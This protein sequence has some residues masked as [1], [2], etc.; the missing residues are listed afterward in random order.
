[1]KLDPEIFV[2][3]GMIALIAGVVGARLSHVLENWSQFTN[4]DRG[5]FGNLWD[6][7]NIRT[8][9]LTFY[10]GFILA[11]PITIAYGIYR[12]VPIKRG[13]DIVAP[14]VMIGLGLGRVGC[15]L[16][17]CCYGAPTDASFIGAVQY[18][19]YSNAYQDQ[20]YKG[21][22]KVPEQLTA[23]S[24]GVLPRL[25][26]TT[27]VSARSQRR[28][29]RGDAILQSGS[30]RANLQHDHCPSDRGNLRGVFLDDAAAGAGNGVNADA[31]RNDAIH[32]GIAALRA[33]RGACHGIRLEFEHGDRR[34]ARDHRNHHVVRIPRSCQG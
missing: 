32:P 10:G 6:A 21:Q 30:Q 18:P 8:G 27:E 12:K 4:H 2:N 5:F 14:C 7:V 1:M 17:G 15:F 34:V 22:L 23:P 3:A 9:G 25:L 16:N 24:D 19:Y 20:Y 31:G 11:F 33:A 26:D 29:P 28:G 13:M